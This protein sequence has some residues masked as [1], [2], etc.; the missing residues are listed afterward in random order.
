[1]GEPIAINAELEHADRDVFEFHNGG[2]F[3][4][5]PRIARKIAEKAKY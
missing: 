4:D 1:L 2:I 5:L 3:L